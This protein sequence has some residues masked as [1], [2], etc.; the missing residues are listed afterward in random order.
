MLCAV[1]RHQSLNTSICEWVC[2]FRQFGSFAI[3]ACRIS[4]FLEKTSAVTAKKCTWSSLLFVDSGWD[5]AR[6][7]V[8]CGALCLVQS[9]SMSR[10]SPLSRLNPSTLGPK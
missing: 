7:V 3:I 5:G 6:L 2:K 10:I 4:S 8:L 9:L 1:R